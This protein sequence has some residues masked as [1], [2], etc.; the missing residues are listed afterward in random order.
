[1]KRTLLYLII[2]ILSLGLISGI[3][4]QNYLNQDFNNLIIDWTNEGWTLDKELGIIYQTKSFTNTK[5]NGTNLNNFRSNVYCG[6][7]PNEGFNLD[8]IRECIK[9]KSKAICKTEY[10]MKRDNCFNEAQQEVRDFHIWQ[11]KVVAE[12]ISDEEIYNM[13]NGE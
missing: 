9:A 2:G 11:Q 10:L 1:M 3:T 8:E 6:E 4:I 12:T 13:F 5:W 7:K